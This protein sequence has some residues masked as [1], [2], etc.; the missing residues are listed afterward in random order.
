MIRK[1]YSLIIFFLLIVALGNAQEHSLAEQAF[2]MDIPHESG[3]KLTSD[4]IT[5]PSFST[6][7]RSCNQLPIG[8]LRQ[9]KAS[10]L[11]TK[12]ALLEVL[13][14]FLAHNEIEL[15]KISWVEN[16]QLPEEFF[17]K[18]N[19]LYYPHVQKLIL[20]TNAKVALHG[21]I[22][23]DIHSLSGYITYLQNA[24]FLND[25]FKI[26]DPC[27]YM[28]F[29]GDY[30]D[31]GSYG[32]EVIYTLLRLKIA[33][34]DHVFLVR[35]NHEDIDQ[36]TGDFK[37]EIFA[38]F[39]KD[40]LPIMRAIN[41]MYQRLPLALYLGAGTKPEYVLCCH[42]GIEWGYDPA[43][44][45]ASSPARS[46]E[47]LPVL[48][49]VKHIEN[50]P[51]VKKVIA[52]VIKNFPAHQVEYQDDI[53]PKSPQHP[54]TNGFMWFDFHTEKD[55]ELPYV[56]F[57]VRRSWTLGQ[58]VS[59]AL[60]A[61]NNIKAVFRA[62]QH[63][64]EKMMNLIL[65]KHKNDYDADAGVCKLWNAD[66]VKPGQ[67]KEGMVL[68][69]CVSP[70]NG[71]GQAKGYNYDSFGILHLAPSFEQWRLDMQRIDAEGQPIVEINQAV[72]QK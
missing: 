56:A 9:D 14:V 46:A 55:Q 23:G 65:K 54:I 59:E 35:G 7:K 44:L 63:G 61:K 66:D 21:D 67:L 52:Q 13:N 60:L 64:D 37:N 50:L 19:S 6:W 27:F 24:N 40:S 3:D 16:K 1:L 36:N 20:P 53:Q 70:H 38:K 42:G 28:I 57:S 10:E 25:S 18:N 32:A 69:F 71:F 11:L 30:V 43:Q 33:N 8:Y 51:E 49:R 12:E 15:K 4:G 41:C 5:H 62:H 2:L 58:K 31:R 34:P 39:K 26:I 45:L 29:L 72:E 22:H 68:T 47:P 17:E 48:D